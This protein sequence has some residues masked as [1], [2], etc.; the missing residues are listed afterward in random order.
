MAKRY[1]SADSA[2]PAQPRLLSEVRSN[3]T[4]SSRA[5]A[6]DGVPTLGETLTRAVPACYI[7]TD[8]ATAYI[9]ATGHFC[10][11]LSDYSKGAETLPVIHPSIG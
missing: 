8:R 10:P 1:Y 7:L 11:R 3:A 9:G 2:S 6:P 5:F 4:G